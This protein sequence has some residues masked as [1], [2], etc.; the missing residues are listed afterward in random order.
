VINREISV[1]IDARSL[2]TQ[3]KTVLMCSVQLKSDTTALVAIDTSRLSAN[4]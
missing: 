2:V 4:Q 3:V 1:F